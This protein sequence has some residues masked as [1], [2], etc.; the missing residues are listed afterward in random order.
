MLELPEKAVGADIYE[1]VGCPK[2]NQ[3]GYKGRT[4]VYEVMPMTPGLKQM[5]LD[6]ESTYKMKDQAV[7]DGMLTLRGDAVQ[8]ML[9]GVT[10]FEEVLRET[11]V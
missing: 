11:M 9:A 3:T 7:K 2:C 6:E 10:S 4:G 5:V 8:K 1:P